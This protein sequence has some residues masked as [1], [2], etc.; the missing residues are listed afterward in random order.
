ML[1]TAAFNFSSHSVPTLE[2]ACFGGLVLRRNLLRPQSLR[3]ASTNEAVTCD[4]LARDLIRN[5]EASRCYLDRLSIT[6]GF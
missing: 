1:A 4:G 6:A 2:C 5:A 3:I